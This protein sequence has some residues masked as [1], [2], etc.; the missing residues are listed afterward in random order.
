MKL[1]RS[2]RSLAMTFDKYYPAR[3]VV[4]IDIYYIIS[5]IIAISLG[6]NGENYK[7]IN[8]P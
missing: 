3:P 8:S 7:C 1:P 5:Y 6:G 2:L 4:L